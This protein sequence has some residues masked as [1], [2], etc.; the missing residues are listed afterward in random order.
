MRSRHQARLGALLLFAAATAACTPPRSE[1]T[2]ARPSVRAGEKLR[3][4]VISPERHDIV[5]GDSLRLASR[6][7][8]SRGGE[9]PGAPY[10][11]Y[12]SLDAGVATVDEHTGWM[13]ALS[14]GTASVVA[15]FAG[16]A[17][18]TEV[19]VGE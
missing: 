13:R 17:D 7:Y 12:R 3:R 19:R 11:R 6:M 16:R 14:A 2:A 5:V 4:V 8:F 9:L 15:E 10:V 1:P 18:T